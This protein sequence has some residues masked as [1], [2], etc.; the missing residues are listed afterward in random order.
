M[1]TKTTLFTTLTAGLAIAFTGCSD[2]T[3][4]STSSSNGA[5]VSAVPNSFAAVTDKLDKDGDL[6]LYYSTEEVVSTADQYINAIGSEL[7]QGFQTI[8]AEQAMIDSG[9]KVGQAIFDQSGIKDISGVGM[10][11]IEFEPDMFRYKVAIHHEE[12]KSDG[13]IWSILGSNKPRELELLKLMPADTALAVSHEVN[14]KELF[15][16]MPELANATDN[17]EIKEQVKM[18]MAMA[19]LMLKTPTSLESLGNQFSLF[20]TLDSNDKTY[21]SAELGGEIPN[22]GLALVIKVKDSTVPDMISQALEAQGSPMEE[23]TIN[24]TKSM[25]FTEASPFPFP[26]SPTMFNLDNH[27]ILASSTELAKKIITTHQGNEPGLTSTEEYKRMAKGLNTEA[28]HLLYVSKRFGESLGPVIK[29]AIESAGDLSS[30]IPIDTNNLP[31]DISHLNLNEIINFQILAFIRNNE[32]GI[33]IQ[34]KSYKDATTVA[35]QS[36]GF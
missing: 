31:F 17:P 7:T 1:K 21:L 27:F 22:P 20:I 30:V 19:G 13:K 29:S 9:M 8:P 32:D 2:S 5:R 23:Q 6:F 4:E 25:V 16:W 35:L 18:A 24:G 11:S 26:V 28:N 34:L 12:S 10:S 33:M 15:T 36:K 3:P 14:I